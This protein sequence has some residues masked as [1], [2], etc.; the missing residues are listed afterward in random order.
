MAEFNTQFINIFKKSLESIL[1]PRFFNSER[2]Y[3]GALI[4]ELERYFPFPLFKGNPI[5]EQEYQKTLPEHGITIRPDIIVH[6]PFE[7]GLV[8][9]RDQGN[10]VVIQLKLKAKESD[11]LDDFRKIDLM[12]DKLEYPMGTFLNIDSSNTFFDCYKGDFPDR[13]HCFS[14][15][16]EDSNILINENH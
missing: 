13:L 7:R 15:R 5:I 4:A 16:L 9:S 3:Q 6:I 11:A 14:V 2:G 12:F 10:F 1:E 8:E